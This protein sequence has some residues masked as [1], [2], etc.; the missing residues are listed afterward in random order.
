MAAPRENRALCVQRCE[1][2]P[3]DFG[4]SVRSGPDS[5][6]RPP[7]RVSSALAPQLCSSSNRLAV[8]YSIFLHT[9]GLGIDDPAM[10][11]DEQTSRAFRDDLSKI[12][13]LHGEFIAFSGQN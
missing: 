9:G 1:A 10:V 12:A 6:F 7:S 3:A 8:C 2:F 11:D 4:I 5:I 13:H